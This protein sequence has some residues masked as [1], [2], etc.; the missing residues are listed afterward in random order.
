M[1]G[2]MK[3]ALFGVIAGI[4]GAAAWAVIAYY[5]NLE[6]G[7]LAWGIGAAVGAAVG[8]GCGVAANPMSGGLAAGIAILSIVAGKYVTVSMMADREINA[9]QMYHD[10]TNKLDNEEYLISWIADDV[11][12]SW[13]KDGKQVQWPSGVDRDRAE[14]QA[15]YPPTVWAH[16]S[17]VWQKMNAE[18]KQK[19]RQVV[20]GILLKMRDRLGEVKA[21][22]MKE[23][24][25][26]SFGVLDIVFFF[27]G[28]ATAWRLGQQPISA[29]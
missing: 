29:T 17:A 20:A 14:H 27:L 23:A 2:M 24:F 3:G 10:W 1:T 18:E 7:W 25:Q 19:H 16:A 8:F 9:D 5:A 22:A 11:A 13:E 21:A 28:A 6:I 4:V 26:N 15:D 12:N